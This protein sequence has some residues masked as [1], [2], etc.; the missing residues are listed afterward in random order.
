MNDI[1]VQGFTPRQHMLAD[2]IWSIE[3]GAQ[4][5]RFLKSLPPAERRDADIVVT[6]LTAAFLDSVDSV[7]ESVKEMLDRIA[8]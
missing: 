4:V 3:D 2:I 5:Q 8:G 1:Q 6:M 7:D